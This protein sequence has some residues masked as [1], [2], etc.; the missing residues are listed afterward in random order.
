MKYIRIFEL[1]DGDVYDV[2]LD[3]H[4]DYQGDRPCE[5]YR[6][7]FVTK[8][9]VEYHVSIAIKNKSE[10]K[11]DF[12]SGG[13]NPDHRSFINLINTGDAIKVFNTLKSIIEKHKSE[14]KKL[15]MNSSPDRIRFYK[16]M[17]DHMKIRNEL[18][19]TYGG[20][21]LYGYLD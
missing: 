12:S 20:S 1:F 14:I 7:S 2:K 8:N 21:M 11:I 6:Y 18:D 3:E 9:G 5:V 13:E 4:E 17:L 16:R 15:I 19:P 10:A